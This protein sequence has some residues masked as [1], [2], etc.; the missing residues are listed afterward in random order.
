M[1]IKAFDLKFTGFVSFKKVAI[2]LCLLSSSVPSEEELKEYKD[3]LLAK[4]LEEHEGHHY[5]GKNVF[6]KVP[7]WFDSNETSV[8]LPQYEP[9]PRVK[10]LK[11]ILFDVVKTEDFLVNIEEFIGLLQIKIPE[12][13]VN[14]TSGGRSIKIYG[15]VIK[16]EE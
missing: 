16:S 7:A 8:D 13:N 3:N 4:V 2:T 5:V 1:L 15:D 9:Y 10:N 11:S 14:V 12:I 6:I